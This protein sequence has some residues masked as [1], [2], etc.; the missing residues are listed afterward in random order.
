MRPAV[1]AALSLLLLLAGGVTR[2][3]ADDAAE[4]I[5]L[6]DGDAWVHPPSGFRFPPDVGTFTRVSAFRYDEDGQDVSVGYSDR[7]LKVILTTYVYPNRGQSLLRHFEQVKRDVVQI[8]PGAEPL[9]EGPWELEQGN[10]KFNGRRAAFAFRITVGDR[11]H[12][13]ISEAYLLRVGEHFIK[14]RVTCPKEKYEPAE[15]RVARFLQSLKLPGPTAAA[16]APVA[17]AVPAK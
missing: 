6:P 16:A 5:E 1:L 9:T 10:R 7:A 17:P 13:V 3:R 14:F 4:P 12:D 15:D 8:H 2:A 11:E